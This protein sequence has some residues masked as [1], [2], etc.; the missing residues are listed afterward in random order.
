M[1][2]LITRFCLFIQGLPTIEGRI[3]TFIFNVC[4]VCFH[5]DYW[6]SAVVYI[7]ALVGEAVMRHWNGSTTWPVPE[8]YAEKMPYPKYYT[9]N[10]TIIIQGQLPLFIMLSFILSVIQTTKAIVYEKE[11]KIKVSYFRCDFVQT[12]DECIFVFFVREKEKERKK[13]GK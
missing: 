7:Q 10:M 9:D 5:L 4:D 1:F 3:T 13:E 8:V 2:Y 12:C 6:N 11:R